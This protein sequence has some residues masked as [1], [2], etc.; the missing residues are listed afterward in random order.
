MKQISLF[1]I[2]LLCLSS[3]FSFAQRNNTPIV[4]GCP[5]YIYYE[6]DKY[7]LDKSFLS[8]FE[9]YKQLYPDLQVKEIQSDD[10]RMG[11][12]QGQFFSPIWLI[13]S[14]QLYMIGLSFFQDYDTGIP[15]KRFRVIEELTGEK[16]EKKNLE[17]LVKEITNGNGA[18]GVL[19]ASWVT[20]TF[21][22]KKVRKPGQSYKNW[23]KE[24]ILKL[25]IKGGKVIK[26]EKI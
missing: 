22:M 19:H 25:T 20:G 12:L 1:V 14:S 2:V 9:N 6:N 17:T 13:E 23:E 11:M 26:A 10:S 7:L 16:F 18:D 8:S 21:Y 3:L 4:F 5:D 15:R 24:P